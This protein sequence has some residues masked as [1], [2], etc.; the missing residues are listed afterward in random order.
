MPSCVASS[1]SPSVS[2][3]SA[4]VSSSKRERA[5]AVQGMVST[6]PL[7]AVA[8]PS[9]TSEDTMSKRLSETALTAIFSVETLS[10]RS[11]F[12]V[13]ASGA[14]FPLLITISSRVARLPSPSSL[15]IPLMVGAATTPRAAAEKAAESITPELVV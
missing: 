8:R 5:A 12:V 2:R 13:T 6:F 9:R 1:P 11:A 4:I 10:S 7:P 3:M 14:M 15:L